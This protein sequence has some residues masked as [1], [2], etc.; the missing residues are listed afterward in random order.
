VRALAGLVE[1]LAAEA[2]VRCV[3]S[4]EESARGVRVS[5]SGDGCGELFGDEAHAEAVE[6]LLHRAWARGGSG[7]GLILDIEGRRERRDRALEE[8]AR[9]IAAEVRQS[10]KAQEMPPANAYERR[11]AHMALA[12]EPGVRSGSVGEGASRRVI[13]SPDEASGPGGA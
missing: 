12:D 9:R 13:V 8:E 11:I 1:R 3:V 2:G 6:H 7:A 10:G 5:V 4:A